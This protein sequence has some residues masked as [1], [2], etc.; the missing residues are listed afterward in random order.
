MFEYAMDA[1]ID[2]APPQKL[3]KLIYFYTVST[4]FTAYIAYTVF[5]VACMPEYIARWLK[6]LKNIGHHW[7]W[8]LHAVIGRW[9]IGYTVTTTRAS[10]VLKQCQ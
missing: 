1:E 6:H 10:A 3:L 8:E 4:A 5:T 2:V 9:I 7:F